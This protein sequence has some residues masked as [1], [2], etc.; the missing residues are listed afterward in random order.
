MEKNL[1]WMKRI[2]MKGKTENKGK[3]WD[4]LALWE[5]QHRAAFPTCGQS[6][7]CFLLQHIQ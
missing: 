6:E 7:D 3:D 2:T 4:R 1:I 5:T